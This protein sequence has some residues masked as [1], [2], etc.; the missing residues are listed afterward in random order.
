MNYQTL[1]TLNY[2]SLQTNGSDAGSIGIKT[3]DRE[4][5]MDWSGTIATGPFNLTSVVGVFAPGYLYI[6]KIVYYLNKVK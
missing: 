5:I 2:S 4:S 6:N 1:T 3:I